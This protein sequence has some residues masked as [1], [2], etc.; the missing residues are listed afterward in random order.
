MSI[1]A[2]N[3]NKNKRRQEEH[4]KVY[5][6]LEKEEKKITRLYSFEERNHS[7]ITLSDF[8]W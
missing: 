2:L 6:R 7:A 3:K 5:E 1:S 4:N 8:Q